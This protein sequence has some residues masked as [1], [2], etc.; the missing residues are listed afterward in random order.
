MQESFW[1]A[2]GR[3]FG[4][5]IIFGFPLLMTMEM[6]WLGFYMD[7]LRLALFLLLMVPVLIGLSYYSGFRQTFDW[8]E[9]IEDAFVAYAVGLAVSAVLLSIFGVLEP[10][11]PLGEI[12]GKIGLQAVPASI[13]AILA[14]TQ[15]GQNREVTERRQ[16]QASYRGEM[17][18]MA[19]GALFIAF[20]V[21]PTE[22]IVLIA[23]QMTP[24]H[25]L[26]LMAVSLL[27][28]HAF[29]Y[30]LGFRG[31]EVGPPG[32]GLR[33]LFLH[34]TVVGYAIALLVSLY[35]LWTFGRLD[36]TGPATLAMITIVLGF[37]SALGAAAAR[38]LL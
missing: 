38:L 1:V 27:L 37:P 4:G 10:G 9:D 29:V 22:E 31:Q 32:A 5:A 8:S 11:M 12:L 30:A 18:L 26:A 2:L 21:A 20:N 3:A 15:L 19:A 16:Q 33:H 35:V 28:M 25:A 17:F 34:F 6:W 7:R 13:G 36:G 14:Q 24:W 23:F